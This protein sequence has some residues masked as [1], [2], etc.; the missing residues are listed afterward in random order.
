MQEASIN[1]IR[2][3]IKVK[4]VRYLG[5]IP[6][7]WKLMMKFIHVTVRTTNTAPSTTLLCCEFT[8]T[9]SYF[10]KYNRLLSSNLLR[11]DSTGDQPVPDYVLHEILANMFLNPFILVI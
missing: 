7:T 10:D 11:C 1:E 6:P 8:V 5:Y 4:T 9:E 3:K 2:H